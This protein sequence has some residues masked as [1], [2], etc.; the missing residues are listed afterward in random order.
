MLGI[1]LD[2]FWGWNYLC[3]KFIVFPVL[4]RTKLQIYIALSHCGNSIFQPILPFVNFNLRPWSSPI[5][6]KGTM[7]ER[8]STALSERLVNY[9]PQNSLKS[10]HLFFQ[11]SVPPYQKGSFG[12]K[13]LRW[14]VQ[15]YVRTFDVS[16]SVFKHSVLLQVKKHTFSVSYIHFP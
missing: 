4:N 14:S 2:L 10:L 8:I 12:V 11:W 1:I 3:W 7:S 16:E 5:L 13:T 15:L 9:S 6:P